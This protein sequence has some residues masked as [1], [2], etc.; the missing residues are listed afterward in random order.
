M[1]KDGKRMLWLR[2]I[3]STN[4]AALAGTE[5]GGF[6]RA[7]VIPEESLTPMQPLRCHPQS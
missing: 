4:A 6:H 1:A 2:S 7:K 3:D 5:G